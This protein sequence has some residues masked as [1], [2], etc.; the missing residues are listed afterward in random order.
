M[1]KI[2]SKNCFSFRWLLTSS[3]ALVLTS[4]GGGGGDGSSGSLEE[5]LSSL[6]EGY[7]VPQSISTIPAE[8][9]SQVQASTSLSSKASRSLK[10]SSQVAASA[11][12]DYDAAGDLELKISEPALDQFSIIETIMGTL[13]QTNYWDSKVVNKG[14]YKTLVKWEEEDGFE[15]QYWTINSKM[16]VV[17][18]KDINRVRFWIDGDEGIRGLIDIYSAP[19]GLN[20]NGEWR[21][22]VSF[23]K[24]GPSGQPGT[25]SAAAGKQADGIVKLSINADMDGTSGVLYL[26]NG[27][28]KGVVKYLDWSQCNSND[29]MDSLPSITAKMAYNENHAIIQKDANAARCKDRNSFADIYMDYKIFNASGTDIDKVK[30]YSFPLKYNN[31]YYYYGGGNGRQQL[32]GEGAETL[33]LSTELEHADHDNSSSFTIDSRVKGILTKKSGVEV[34]LTDNTSRA[35]GIGSD[36]LQGSDWNSSK[37][38][39]LIYNSGAWKYCNDYQFDWSDQTC[40]SLQALGAGDAAAIGNTDA[41][42]SA[43]NSNNIR[44][45]VTDFDDR[46]WSNVIDGK[47]NA[48]AFSAALDDTKIY[49][50]SYEKMIFVQYDGTVDNRWET[51]DA[52]Y[53]VDPWS[54]TL[55]NCVALV[56]NTLAEDWG[57]F[58]RHFWTNGGT[59]YVALIDE[60][61]TA[62]G[63]TGSGDLLKLVKKKDE[64]IKTAVIGS[65]TGRDYSGAAN[66]KAYSFDASLQLTDNSDSSLVT[67]WTDQI[68][69]DAGNEY[70]WEYN[71]NGDWDVMTYLAYG[72]NPPSGKSQ[73]DVVVFDT[74]LF[75]DSIGAKNVAGD[76]VTLSNLVYDGWI[77]GLPDVWSMLNENRNN[78]A[79]AGLTPAQKAKIVNIPA[80][81]SMV[82]SIGDTFKIKPRYGMRI[83]DD[84][85]LGGCSTSIDDSVSLSDGITFRAHDV[86]ADPGIADVTVMEGQFID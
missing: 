40:S 35:A 7:S 20:S 28:G 77:S 67:N 51:C 4:C 54:P 32:W 64:V 9:T 75:F 83:L 11:S 85:A 73:G 58:S 24:S 16:I 6:T 79:D 76:N 61:T 29:C 60:S 31:Q 70:Q 86:G 59:Q 84:I 82:D 26:D 12:T 52:D 41:I 71:S 3:M 10:R 19:T 22:D 30:T 49:R 47:A 21:L 39:M 34:D 63:N 37:H 45:Q 72:V 44:V 27:N 18:G 1:K 2:S 25:F 57:K 53:S 50:V 48:A 17:D 80:G 33:A 13:K 15:Y 55:S 42:Y 68:F 81:T 56:W 8:N 62:D 66:G 23:E 38:F 14:A 74:P 36:I 69:D 65:L 46:Q 78:D 43:H 5:V